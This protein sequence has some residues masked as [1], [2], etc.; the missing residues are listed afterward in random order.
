MSQSTLSVPE[1]SCNA[2]RTTI[3]EAA[4]RRGGRR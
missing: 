2:C 1:M 4:G 3:E